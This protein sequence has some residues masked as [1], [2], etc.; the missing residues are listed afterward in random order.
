MVCAESGSK[1]SRKPK[2]KS[3]GGRQMADKSGLSW[4]A[5][6]QTHAHQSRRWKARQLLATLPS[7][8]SRA[9]FTAPPFHCTTSSPAPPLPP[10]PLPSLLPVSAPSGRRWPTRVRMRG[11]RGSPSPRAAAACSSG[12]AAAPCCWAAGGWRACRVGVRGECSTSVPWEGV[13]WP[14]SPAC[15][16]D[17]RPSLQHEGGEQGRRWLEVRCGAGQCWPRKQAHIQSCASQ[18]G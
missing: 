17:S 3:Q 16:S 15:R 14:E 13:G 10:P 11:R 12:R 2:R 5:L 4:G 6:R 9:R 7:K 8:Q 18:R 1:E